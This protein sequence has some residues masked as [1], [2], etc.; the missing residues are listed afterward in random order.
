MGCWIHAGLE[1][2]SQLKRQPKGR[3]MYNFTLMTVKLCVSLVCI[4]LFEVTNGLFVDCVKKSQL[5]TM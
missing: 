3:N 2:Y 4:S 5:I 1:F